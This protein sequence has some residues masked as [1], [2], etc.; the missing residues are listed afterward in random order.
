MPSISQ[1]KYFALIGH[2]PHPKQWL[3]HRSKARFRVPCCGRRFGKS[4]MGARDEEPRLLLPDRR[5][6]C[7]GPTYD[8]AEKEFRVIW[9]DMIIGLKFASDKRIRRAY[10]KRSGEMYIEFPWQTRIECRSADHPENLVGERLDHVIMSEAAK[11]KKDTWERYIQPALADRRGSATFPSTPEGFNWFY[12]LWQQG[13]DPSFEDT[14]SWQFPSWDNPIVY[15]D[16]RS[17]SEILRL[18]RV[19]TKEWF[20]QEIAA[21]F[22]AFV[23]KIFGDFA[24][25][26]HVKAHEFNPEWRNYIAFDWGY[27]NPLAAIEF[28]V[29]PQDEIFVWREHYKPYLTLEEHLNILKT[30]ENPEGYRLDLCFGDS[31]DPEAAIYVSQHFAP[32]IAMPE[33]KNNW[34]EG[35]DL[36]NVFLKIR[37]P[38]DFADL[39]DMTSELDLSFA[40]SLRRPG[41]FIDHSCKNTIREMNGY[42]TPQS[43]TLVNPR[44]AAQKYDDHALD[45]LRYGLMHVFKLGCG[46]SSLTDIYDPRGMVW[47]SD[48]VTTASGFTTYEGE[49]DAGSGFFTFPRSD[50][51][52][53]D[54]GSFFS[55]ADLN[56]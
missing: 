19:S 26:T 54:S 10:N 11:H 29:S 5:T 22:T 2:K 4:M 25:V 49:G 15:P 48:R 9:N 44:E 39:T 45:A 17:D 33:A 47:G 16:G 55:A 24:E 12:D 32:C 38:S 34:R 3:F 14:E 37:E 52:F 8:L 36:I 35:I 20:E 40:D 53:D 1:D 30:R 28:Q 27:T 7:V 50:G 43:R 23:G 56:F 21:S 31:A 18:E 6:W 51:A 46:A 42:R 41:L 13:Q